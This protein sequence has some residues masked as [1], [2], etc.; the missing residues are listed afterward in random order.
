[1]KYYK[2]DKG[3]MTLETA[4]ILPIFFFLFMG[5]FG[6]FGF[7]AARNQIH[8]SLIQSAKSL[9][10]DSYVVEKKATLGSSDFYGYE[11]LG[12]V[13]L[14]IWR[15]QYD[16]NYTHR[17][18][19]YEKTSNK[20]VVKDRFVAYLVGSGNDKD[21]NDKL[22][23]IGVKD[24]L[25]GIKFSYSVT[26]GDLK[27]TVKYKLHLWIDFFGVGNF[28]IEDSV[29]VKMWGYDKTVTSDSSSGGGASSDSDDSSEDSDIPDETE[30]SKPD[31]D[32][33]DIP[34]ETEYSKPDADSVVI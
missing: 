17:T 6:F 15:V 16:Q 13:I 14:D 1:M 12:D 26:D 30:Y 9:S 5:I 27:V 25:N 32:S 21:A 4:I 23:S 10:M 28:P 31:A 19:W 7:I 3:S 20:E 24:G 8:H 22:K 34:D 29:V 11:S 18:N 2:H 33:S